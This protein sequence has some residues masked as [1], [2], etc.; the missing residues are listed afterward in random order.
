MT[1][2]PLTA[3]EEAGLRADLARSNGPDDDVGNAVFSGPEQAEEWAARLLATLDAARKAEAPSPSD[4]AELGAEIAKTWNGVPDP[5]PFLEDALHALTGGDAA[6]A[7]LA[8]QRGLAVMSGASVEDRL[9]GRTVEAHECLCEGAPWCVPHLGR[10]VRGDEI[11]QCLDHDHV[12]PIIHDNMPEARSTPAA[13]PAE[14][15]D[16]ERLAAEIHAL[17]TG[18]RHKQ[19]VRE[20]MTDEC[21]VFARV[22]AERLSQPVLQPESPTTPEERP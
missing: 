10:H 19:N 17:T 18:I 11:Y 12:D 20:G 15:L 13:R 1:T 9:A 14:G 8:I 2:E 3:E 6:G 4:L 5:R 16:V 7:R 22:I 21:Q